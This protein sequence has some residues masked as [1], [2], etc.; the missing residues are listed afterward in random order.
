[1]SKKLA[2]K[3]SARTEIFFRSVNRFVSWD[4]VPLSRPSPPHDTPP[5]I[6][7]CMLFRNTPPPPPPRRW[8][9]FYLH[10][11][12]KSR[13]YAFET[14]LVLCI[15]QNVFVIHQLHCKDKAVELKQATQSNFSAECSVGYCAFCGAQWRNGQWYTVTQY[16]TVYC[17]SMEQRMGKGSKNTR[18]HTT[19]TAAC[20]SRRHNLVGSVLRLCVTVLCLISPFAVKHFSLADGFESPISHI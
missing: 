17:G 5:L 19:S 20:T 7:A 2:C 6:V 16:G 1:M 9:R 13:A 10:T 3:C 15:A 8:C 12:Y 18:I 14:L 11:H 4:F